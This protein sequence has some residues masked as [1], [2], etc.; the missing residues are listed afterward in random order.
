M[1]FKDPLVFLLIPLLLAIIIWSRRRQRTASLRFPSSDLVATL[2]KTWKIRFA[3]VPFYLRLLALVLLIF[4]LAGPRAILDE[5]KHESEGIDIV[6]AIDGSGSMAAEDFTLNGRRYNRLEVVKNVVKD[7]IDGRHS[8]RIALIAFA[9]LAYTVSP[10]TTDYTWLKT[11]LDRVTLNMMEDGT[12]IG[13]A[14]SASLSRL[15]KS[16]AKSKIVILLTDGI[17]NRGKV[18]PISAGQAARALGVKIYTIGAGTNGLAPYPVQDIWGRRG[19]Q[20]EPVKIDEITLKR[21]ANITN[22]Q[23]YRA[24]DTNSLRQI[25]QEID[26]LEKTKIEETGYREYKE[27]FGYFLTVAL[28]LL[29]LAL[30]LENTIFLR[31]P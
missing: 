26:R 3:G 24:T 15:Q 21:I 23:Y 5:S 7:F 8:D 9:G 19:Y 16:T 10:L 13:S 4:A 2:Q 12:A 29:L 1:I 22:G 14:I 17:N 25:Y 6:L 28:L 11:N 27:L 30:V 31:L 18:D 20:N